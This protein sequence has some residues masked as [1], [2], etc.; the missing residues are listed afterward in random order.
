MYH[1]G[2]SP[3]RII[4]EAETA[5]KSAQLQRNNTWSRFKKHTSQ[6]EERGS[7]RWRTLFDQVLKPDQLYLFSQSCY[8]LDAQKEKSVDHLELFV[9]LNDPENGVIKASRFNSAVESVGYEGV[10]DKAVIVAITQYLKESSKLST[11]VAMA[12]SR[13]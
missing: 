8:M 11:S 6:T 1:E 10:L 5:L 4:D 7:V 9:R 2:E 13:S 3:T 12:S